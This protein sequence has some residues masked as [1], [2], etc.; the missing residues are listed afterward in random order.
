VLAEGTPT[1]GGTAKQEEKPGR[2]RDH[3]ATQDQIHSAVAP[4]KAVGGDK[5]V[6][7]AS[8]N[9]AQRACMPGCWTR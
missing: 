7:A 5:T 9:I 8:A 2:Q 4:A 3:T 1:N 6:T